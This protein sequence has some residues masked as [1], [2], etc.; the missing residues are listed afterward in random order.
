MK[1]WTQVGRNYL[2]DLKELDDR[3]DWIHFAQDRDQ[4]WPFS[5]SIKRWEFEW[6]SNC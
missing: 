6:L 4:L 3:I 5:G 1:I 2:N